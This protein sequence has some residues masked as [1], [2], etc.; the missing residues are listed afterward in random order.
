MPFT[1]LIFYGNNA[2]FYGFT[3]TFVIGMPLIQW[4]P[5]SNCAE[6]TRLKFRQFTKKIEASPRVHDFASEKL[7]NEHYAHKQE[8]QAKRFLPPF[9]MHQNHAALLWIVKGCSRSPTT[10][11]SF[12][13]SVTDH[14]CQRTMARRQT[15]DF[16][17]SQRPALRT[18]GRHLS[19]K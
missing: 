7:Q 13:T 12:A 1:N 18:D 10:Y 16:V 15:C 14:R 19:L 6:T 5:K 17:A 8:L 11:L 2:T 4:W 9:A 3:K